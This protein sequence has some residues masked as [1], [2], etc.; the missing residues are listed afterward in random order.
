MTL[1]FNDVFRLMAWIFLGAM[2][3]IPLCKP[4]AAGAPKP[5]SDH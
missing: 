2:I 5:V 3:M 1:A 4:P